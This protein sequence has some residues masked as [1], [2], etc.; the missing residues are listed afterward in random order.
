MPGRNAA[1]SPIILCA[2]DYGLTAGV[3]R[4]ILELAQARRISATS[5]IVNLP[6]W[7][8]DGP[9]VAAVRDR[10]SI[11]LHINLTLGG[12]LGPMPRL[13][14]DGR[15]PSIGVLVRAALTGRLDPGEVEAEVL[16]QIDSFVAA[17]GFA[18]DH[19]DGHQHVHA[20]PRVRDAVLTAFGQRLQATRPLMR[21][22]ADTLARVLRRGG[23]TSKALG[24]ALLSAGFGARARQH[25]MP[26]NRG[27]SGFSNFDQTI[28]YGRELDRAFSHVGPFHIV[29]CHPGDPDAELEGLDPVVARRG[30]EWAVLASSQ[31]SVNRIWHA[32]RAGDGP[33]IDWNREACHEF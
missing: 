5:A 9:A 19:V 31:N 22:P 14:P 28:D 25:E 3:S 24:I 13:A 23:S 10:I 26:V 4:A 11:G 17:T 1:P 32:R 2:D 33:P 15:L 18:P 29:M 27:F 21:D 16:R 30:Q 6:R 20:L 7:A 8:Q 12:P